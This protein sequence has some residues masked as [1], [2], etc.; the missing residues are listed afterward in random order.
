MSKRMAL[1][2]KEEEEE[3]EG[4]AADHPQVEEVDRGVVQNHRCGVL[5]TITTLRP[6]TGLRTTGCS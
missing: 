1:W 6:V 5:A 2:P 4:E 3:E